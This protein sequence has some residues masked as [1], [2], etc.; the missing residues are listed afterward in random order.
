MVRL[1]SRIAR[2]VVQC[3]FTYSQTAL[4]DAPATHRF[5]ILK[6]LQHRWEQPAAQVWQPPTSWYAKVFLPE[7]RLN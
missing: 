5:F 4:I 2:I 3:G 7:C 1:R 6:G